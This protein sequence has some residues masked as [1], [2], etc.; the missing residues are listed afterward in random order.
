MIY[1]IIWLLIIILWIYVFIKLTWKKKLTSD[2]I[3]YFKD[4]IKKTKLLESEKEKLVNFDKIYHKILI[5]A[6]YSWSFWEILKK[7]PKEIKSINNIWELHKIRNKLVHDF[8][9]FDEKV[10]LKKNS[11]Y[12][13]EISNLIDYVS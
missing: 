11:E 10:L 2:K 13:L 7:K 5:E 9:H 6:W 3:K 8:D 12:F 4:I 1:Y